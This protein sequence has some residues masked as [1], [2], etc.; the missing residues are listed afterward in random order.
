MFHFH[1]WEVIK[2][3]H[4]HQYL[5]CRECNKRIVIGQGGYQPIDKQWIET[6][7]FRDIKPPKTKYLPPTRR[8]IVLKH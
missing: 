1:K 7:V 6:G 3:T 4:L 2:D 5:Q 8:N